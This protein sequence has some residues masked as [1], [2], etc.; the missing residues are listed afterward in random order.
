MNKNKKMKVFPTLKRT[1]TAISLA[2]I[3]FMSS[4]HGFEVD[5]IYYSKNSDGKTVSVTYKGTDPEAYDEYSGIVSVPPS[6]SYEGN[7]Y[8]VSSIGYGAF[9]GCTGLTSI[10]IPNSVTII[11]D[12]AFRGCT[13]LSSVNIPSF[14]KDIGDWAFCECSNLSG[15]LIFPTTLS[16]LGEEAFSGC[17]KLTSVKWNAINCNIGTYFSQMPFSNNIGVFVFGDEVQKIPPYI[18]NGLSKITSLSIPYS[19][20]EIG[21]YAFNGCS[22]MSDDLVIPNGVKEIKDYTFCNCKKIKS[23]SIPSGLVS[24]GR[25]S[26]SGCIGLEKVN[27]ESLES[28]LNIPFDLEK[29]SPLGYAHR[30]YLNGEEVTN[31]VIP[32]GVT[33]IYP[34]AFAGCY[35]LKSLTIP[36][37]VV[38]YGASFESCVNL[39]IVT[40]ESDANCPLYDCPNIKTIFWNAENGWDGDDWYEYNGSFFSAAD[41]VYFGPKVKRIPTGILAN[42]NRLKYVFIGEN[43]SEIKRYA[44]KG[45]KTVETVEWNALNMPDFTG[46]V[47]AI[48]EMTNLK[49]LFVG[50]GVEKIPNYLCC[51]NSSL[52]FI[53]IP[54]SVQSIG[55]KSFYNCSGLK[56][57]ISFSNKTFATK[58]NTVIL[59]PSAYLSNWPKTENLYPIVNEINTQT[60]SILSKSNLFGLNNIVF[61]GEN[62]EPDQS[63]NFKLTNLQ[64]S[65]EYKI[66]ISGFFNGTQ[67]VGDMPIITKSNEE[68]MSIELVNRTNKT[69]TVRG[70]YNGD[71]EVEGFSFES[72]GQGCEVT[73]NGLYP[74]ESRKVVFNVL[75]KGITS[76][77]DSVFSTESIKPITTNEI[78]PT[79]C[80][81]SSS[82]ENVIDAEIDDFGF[83]L[84]GLSSISLFG[85]DPNKT[86]NL[87]FYVT[88]KD[89]WTGVSTVKFKTS[90][91]QL[92]TQQ[93][94]LISDNK[95]IITAQTNGI[96]DDLR[97]GFQWRRSDAPSTV[98]SN[99]ARCPV[100]KGELSGSLNDLSPDRYY[101]YRPFYVSDSGN[102]YYGNWM[103]F[104]TAQDYSY[105]E[106]IVHTLVP[107]NITSQSAEFIGYVTPGS[108]DTIEQG[109]EFWSDASSTNTVQSYSEHQTIISTGL[110][111]TAEVGGLKDDTNYCYRSF[112]RT[113]K[114][115]TYGEEIMFNTEKA[116]SVYGVVNDKPEAEVVGYYNLQGLRFEKPQK[117]FN[118]IVYSNGTAKKV[119]VK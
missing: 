118:I 26:F 27:I 77:V 63:N 78:S 110:L 119:V 100:F 59:A 52:E 51:D 37:S 46:S 81:M 62:V 18:C 114:G 11:Y 38:D 112:V 15:E 6:V 47:N 99:S 80:F 32:D 64:P 44:F 98:P 35:S 20:T 34:F 43:V 28:W 109:F 70:V 115:I 71:A 76:S 12:E 53:L 74:G 1:A 57:V 88:T 67:I 33:N 117:G 48:S 65:T 101:Q 96:D 29:E 16:H 42:T 103:V 14:V 60:T 111:M 10:I 82:L 68:D 91:L 106:P 90:Q 93:A 41:S 113:A 30:L 84:S 83:V 21:E 4:S 54:M 95:A 107:K 61:N 8:E 72:A 49:N 23:I 7:T 22:N 19:V 87:D 108:D 92:A 58:N 25:Y 79:T 75:Y 86:Y 94:Q 13:K 66:T 3:P 97:F 56:S 9:S 40:I 24:I 36:S 31:L 17:N 50:N 2:L 85:L 104:L 45:C 105:F 89:G 55:V 73:F 5:G 39:E 116:N 69:I 102:A